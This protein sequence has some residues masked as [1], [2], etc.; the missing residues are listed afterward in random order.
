MCSVQLEENGTGKRENCVLLN[1][2]GYGVWN[3]TGQ[4]F[5]L[6]YIQLNSHFWLYRSKGVDSYISDTIAIP[7]FSFIVSQTSLSLTFENHPSLPC[8]HTCNFSTRLHTW[9]HT[10][11]NLLSLASL[12]G[13]WSLTTTQFSPWCEM[14]SH[15]NGCSGVPTKLYL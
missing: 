6:N 11:H 5:F 7:S 14:S 3:Q 4:V 1:L 10:V 2:Y 12:L 8:D 9:D 13:I 15:R